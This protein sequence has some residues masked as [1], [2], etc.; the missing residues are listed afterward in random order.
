MIFNERKLQNGANVTFYVSDGLGE[1][2]ALLNSY[3]SL[4]ANGAPITK[5]ES[6]LRLKSPAKIVYQ[7]TNALSSTRAMSV[8]G[9]TLGTVTSAGDSL[10]TEIEVSNGDSVTVRFASGVSKKWLLNETISTSVKKTRFTA[11]FRCS[12]NN[13]LYDGIEVS[14]SEITYYQGSDRSSVYNKSWRAESYRSLVFV[15]EPSGDLLTRLQK[16]GVPQ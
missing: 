2:T 6:S 4:T 5:A 14:R 15:E 3:G 8:K 11:G 9:I 7:L 13:K 12:G 10:S 1:A 16:N